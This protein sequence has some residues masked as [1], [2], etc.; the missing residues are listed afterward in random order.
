MSKMKCTP[1]VICHLTLSL[2]G[3]IRCWHWVTCP[4]ITT[5]LF[6]KL[7]LFKTQSPAICYSAQHFFFFYL[8]WIYTYF[9]IINKATGQ[10]YI[11]TNPSWISW[12]HQRSDALRPNIYTHLPMFFMLISFSQNIIVVL[13]VCNSVVM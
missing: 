13:P 11:L 2:W 5:G 12:S 6:S 9:Q 3:C 4:H 10:I 8:Q 1:S 7:L